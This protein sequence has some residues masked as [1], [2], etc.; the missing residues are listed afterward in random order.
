MGNQ[1]KIPIEPPKSEKVKIN[2]GIEYTYNSSQ[3]Y[4]IDQLRRMLERDEYPED[5]LGRYIE[6]EKS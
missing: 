5:L 1:H 4:T 2:S 3:N 6:V